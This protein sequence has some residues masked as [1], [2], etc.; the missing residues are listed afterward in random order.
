MNCFTMF[1]QNKVTLKILD[2]AGISL[3]LNQSKTKA[4]KGLL[5]AKIYN[6]VIL[7]LNEST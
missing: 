1:F 7:S 5:Q 4:T 6:Y 2:G 3:S